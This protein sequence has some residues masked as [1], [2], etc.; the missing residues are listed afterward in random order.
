MPV[1]PTQKQELVSNGWLPVNG[2]KNKFLEICATCKLENRCVQSSTEHVVGGLHLEFTAVFRPYRHQY[3]LTER[4]GQGNLTKRKGSRHKNARRDWNKSV[5]EDGVKLQR[6][7]WNEGK[8][9]ITF[10]HYYNI[11]HQKTYKK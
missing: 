7:A 5:K 3:I 1:F 11:L 9:V 6:L 10:I 4:G 8:K 2:F